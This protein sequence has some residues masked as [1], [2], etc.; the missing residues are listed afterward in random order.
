MPCEPALH[1]SPI[2]QY[3]ESTS[4]TNILSQIHYISQSGSGVRNYRVSQS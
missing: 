1:E 3:Y 2:P 4:H